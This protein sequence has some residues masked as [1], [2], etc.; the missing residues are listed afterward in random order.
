[1]AKLPL[2]RTSLL[3]EGIFNKTNIP[4]QNQKGLVISLA[5]KTASIKEPK[6]SSALV[7]QETIAS[8]L[9]LLQPHLFLGPVIFTHDTL[10]G[11][12]H[13]TRP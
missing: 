8:Y 2:P 1:M 13:L 6:R 10:R 3:R 11:H 12:E 9:F 7:R 5:A 4:N